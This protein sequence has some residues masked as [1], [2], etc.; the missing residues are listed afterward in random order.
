MDIGQEHVAGRPHDANVILNVQGDL[1]VVPPVLPSVAVVRQNRIIEEDMQAVEIGAQA[2][3]HDDVRGDHQKVARQARIRFVGFMKVA[4]SDQQ[5]EHLGLARARGHLDHEARPVLIEHVGGHGTGS[6]E[7]QQ[8]ELVARAACVVQPDHGLDSLALRE[9]IAEL[10][11]RGIRLLDQM[12]GCEPPDQQR[13]RRG[14]GTSVPRVA[15]CLDLFAHLGHQRRHQLLV[16][17]AAQ[18]FRRREPTQIR[19]QHHI[20]RQWEAGMQGHLRGFL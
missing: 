7:A 3:Q 19:L 6:V 20:R 14:G 10:A 13:A 12:I 1:E 5:R 18:L 9:V 17:R 16:S 11:L 2:I 4:P 15:P 8:V